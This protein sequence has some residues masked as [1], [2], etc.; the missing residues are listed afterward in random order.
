MTEFTIPAAVLRGAVT[1]AAGAAARNN[2]IPVLEHLWLHAPRGTLTVRG[3][4][5]E[6]EL[7]ATA[8]GEG[9]L[10]PATVHGAVFTAMLARLPAEARVT[11]EVLRHGLRV[12]A[13]GLRATLPTLPAEDYPEA[14][15]WTGQAA[16]T[17]DAR[18][19]LRL[20]TAPS[21]AVSTDDTRF[22]LNGIFFHAEGEGVAA[23]ATDGHRLQMATEDLA[24]PWTLDPAILPRQSAKRMEALLKDLAGDQPV[25]LRGD[26]SRWQLEAPGW[27]FA[28]K[29]IDGTFPDY[30]RILPPP[31]E[32]EE[33][34]VTDPKALASAVASARVVGDERSFPVKLIR[35][36]GTRA[37]HVV[38][39]SG[40]GGQVEVEVPEAS[41][42]WAEGT[43]QMECAFQ[44]R[45]LADLCAAIPRPFRMRVKPECPARIETPGD[46]AALMPMRAWR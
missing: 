23:V 31:G 20:L 12:S 42:S 11:L 4:D 39:A 2:T 22:Y 7:S 26:G 25:T 43:G 45:Y 36:A 24:E 27:T 15:K 10:G 29:L 40:E 38:G 44:A 8:L 28:T 19:L 41:V 30:K 14:R 21:S 32:G 16:V 1:M 13:P 3:T 46:L 18:P 35:R 6:M 9:Q 34:V 33:L 17:L 5:M 37:L